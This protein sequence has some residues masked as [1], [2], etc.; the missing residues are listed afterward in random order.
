MYGGIKKM[1]KHELVETLNDLANQID[2]D[3]L[4]KEIL[5]KKII[6]F[7]YKIEKEWK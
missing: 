1:S 4:P 2:L 7:L 5:I 3:I 6:E